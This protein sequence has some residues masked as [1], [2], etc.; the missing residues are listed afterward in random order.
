[1]VAVTNGSSAQYTMLSQLFRIFAFSC[2]FSSIEAK[3]SLCSLPM[4]VI[5]PMVGRIMACRL[6]ISP[7]VEMPASIMASVVLVS[8]SHSESGTP[9]CEL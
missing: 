4:L 5:T 1:M 6:S 9:I 8:M 3:P 7:V 2:A